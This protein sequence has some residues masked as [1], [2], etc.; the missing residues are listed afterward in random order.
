MGAC[1][2]CNQP[3]IKPI[4]LPITESA[5]DVVASDEKRQQNFKTDLPLSDL[6]IV[7]MAN[8]ISNIKMSNPIKNL[9]SKRRKRYIQ[10]GY[11]LDL[12]C[13]LFKI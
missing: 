13:I 12:T 11:N 7:K 9:V 1:F 2:S 3:R 5:L 8:T 6:C 10:D 4:I